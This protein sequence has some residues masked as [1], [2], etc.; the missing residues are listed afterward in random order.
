MCVF[1]FCFSEKVRVWTQRPNITIC[2]FLLVVSLYCD[3]KVF[4]S[5][6]LYPRKLKG[7]TSLQFWSSTS[8]RGV[9]VCQRFGRPVVSWNNCTH[10]GVSLKTVYFGDAR[11]CSFCLFCFFLFTVQRL[12][13]ECKYPNSKFEFF[14]IQCANTAALLWKWCG[15][16]ASSHSVLV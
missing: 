7:M 1:C 11:F 2:R 4:K 3:A 9:R 10:D 13:K 12:Q 5:D 6:F 16:K 14:Q 8:M 15:R